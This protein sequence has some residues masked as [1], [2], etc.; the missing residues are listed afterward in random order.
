MCLFTGATA[1]ETRNKV[2][3]IGGDS[4]GHYVPSVEVVDLEDAGCSRTLADFPIESNGVTA[5]LFTREDGSWYVKACGG[6][7]QR[8][9]Y[10]Y[11]G[12]NDEWTNGKEMNFYKYVNYKIKLYR[13]HKL[14][15]QH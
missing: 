3:V 15:L 12:L 6:N 11:D 5:G 7:D 4:D 9:C 8:E 2:L 1:Q 10:D 13:N 14:S